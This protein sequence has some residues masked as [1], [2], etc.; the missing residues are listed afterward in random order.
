MPIERTPHGL[1]PARPRSPEEEDD[2]P[3]SFQLPISHKLQQ[4]LRAEYRDLDH[5]VERALSMHDLA[6]MVVI[7]RDSYTSEDAAIQAR[8][9]FLE[10]RKWVASCAGCEPVQA[11]FLA[12]RYE[13]PRVAQVLLAAGCPADVSFRGQTAEAYSRTCHASC[14][15]TVA[16][17][18]HPSAGAE[19]SEHTAT[20]PSQ[21]SHGGA[22]L[23]RSPPNRDRTAASGH[24]T[25]L[26]LNREMANSSGG[27]AGSVAGPGVDPEPHSLSRSPRSPCASSVPSEDSTTDA[28]PNGSPD[29]EANGTQ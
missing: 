2:R 15:Q 1:Q 25:G 16:S 26:D 3:E 17:Y 5:A 19:H 9:T 13:N 18:L 7:F 4:Q 23:D 28:E 6:A 29:S 14:G 10:L 12:L 24:V 27:E 11:L 20:S 8:E 22:S 21:E